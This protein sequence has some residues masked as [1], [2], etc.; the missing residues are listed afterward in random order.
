MCLGDI[1][2]REDRNAQTAKE[3]ASENDD[4]VEGELVGGMDV[5]FAF[6][7]SVYF[8]TPAGSRG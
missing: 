6:I 1:V 7:D 8:T 2:E 4:G 5:S 3:V